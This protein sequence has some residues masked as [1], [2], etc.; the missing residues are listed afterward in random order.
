MKGVIMADG[1]VVATPVVAQLRQ[2]LTDSPSKRIDLIHVL[3]QQSSS[4][5]LHDAI[6]TLDEREKENS[7]PDAAGPPSPSA[8]STTSSRST[9]SWEDKTPQPRAKKRLS[10]RADDLTAQLKA[11]NPSLA[12]LQP[13]GAGPRGM[14]RT[15]SAPVGWGTGDGDD[16]VPSPFLKRTDR[17]MAK[18]STSAL[19]IRG[20]MLERRPSKPGL[21]EGGVSGRLSGG[22]LSGGKATTIKSSASATGSGSR[23]SLG[24]GITRTVSSKP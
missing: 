11:T 10:G 14:Q 20:P 22:R 8:A 5:P 16:D 4:S 15:M 2:L 19:P 18:M 7:P 21:K 17:A 6:T 9:H 3:D 13:G 12:S 1:Q 23:V 24:K